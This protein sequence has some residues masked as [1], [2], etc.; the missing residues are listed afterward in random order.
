MQKHLFAPEIRERILSIKKRLPSRPTAVADL[1]SL[2]ERFTKAVQESNY[3]QQSLQEISDHIGHY[4]GLLQSVRITLHE[5]FEDK[6]WSVSPGGD[7]YA[8]AGCGTSPTGLYQTRGFDHNE[9]ILVKKPKYGLKHIVAILAHECTHNYLC[10]HNVGESK[11]LD[12]E[13]TA[14][15]TAAYLGLGHL[16]I[17]GYQPIIW[18]TDSYSTEHTIRIGYVTPDTIRKAMVISCELRGWDPRELVAR[19]PSILDKIVVYMQLWPY[20]IKFNRIAKEKKISGNLAEKR[21]ATINCLRMEVTNMRS[22]YSELRDLL[23]TLTQTVDSKKILPQDVSLLV[24]I[25]NKISI[26]QPLIQI[27]TVTVKINSLIAS[28]ITDDDLC[29]VKNQ[30]EYIRNYLQEWR[31]LLCKYVPPDKTNER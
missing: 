29:E 25:S 3:S 24:E 19:M 22:I 20:R 13:I 17:S 6:G 10:F 27:E 30:I 7:V 8:D 5:T 16:L 1:Y 21:T 18:D 23:A 4:L 2:P 26:D 14:D 31:T 12:N 11:R 28:A 9:I 15:L